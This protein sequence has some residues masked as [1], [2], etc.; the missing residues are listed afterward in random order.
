[1]NWPL[2]RLVFSIR[3]FEWLN[4]FFNWVE[5]SVYKW[6]HPRVTSRYYHYWQIIKHEHNSYYK[7][8]PP[9]LSLL[10]IQEEKYWLSIEYCALDNWT[11][12]QLFWLIPK[13]RVLCCFQSSTG[14]HFLKIWR[15]YILDF[16]YGKELKIRPSP[17]YVFEWQILDFVLP[18]QDQ[19]SI[20]LQWLPWMMNGICR[21]SRFLIVIQE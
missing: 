21:V 3:S 6:C 5:S 8:I 13:E 4:W 19:V 10:I 16:N 15:S 14:N 17:Y 12:N 11:R 2:S 1:M 18:W 7:L 20:W 9:P